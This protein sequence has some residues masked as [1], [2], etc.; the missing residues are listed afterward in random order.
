[1]ITTD[2]EW[3]ALHNLEQRQSYPTL[4]LLY[5]SVLN[6]SFE[7][8]CIEIAPRR[9]SPTAISYHAVTPYSIRTP[10]L[11]IPTVAYEQTF[12]DKVFALHSFALSGLP[13][14]KFFISRHY[15]DV[16][17]IASRINIGET[18]HL[19]NDTVKYQTN[20]TTK[21][22]AP[23]SAAADIRLIPGVETLNFLNEDY[24]KFNSHFLIAPPLWAAII[25]K[26]NEFKT[27]LNI[28]S[29]R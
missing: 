10:M 15:F 20:Y 12:W 6:N 9:Y 5:R 21:E 18:Y 16:A 23:I 26:L 2:R 8:I 13:R 28:E 14:N 4:H 22:I 11:E 7:H 3:V 19:F 27:R 25:Q 17:T 1:M 24:D 29:V